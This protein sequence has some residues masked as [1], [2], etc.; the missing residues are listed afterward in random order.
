MN[1]N[2]QELINFFGAIYNQDEEI[3]EARKDLTEQLKSWA[4][5]HEI[6]QKA[7]SSVYN[8]YKKY[9]SGKN[10]ARECEDLSELSG[11]IENYFA[12]SEEL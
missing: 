8:L 10:S 1:L 5:N 7:I 2:D 9:K 12:T 3:R 4:D 6:E 11:I